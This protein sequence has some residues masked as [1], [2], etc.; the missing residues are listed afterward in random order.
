MKAQQF[1]DKVHST[2]YWMVKAQREKANKNLKSISSV[3][4]KIIYMEAGRGGEGQDRK[5]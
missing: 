2:T 5:G 3:N 1:V 4:P